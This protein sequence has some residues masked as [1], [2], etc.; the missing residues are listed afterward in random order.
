M[1]E[2]AWRG[3]ISC[4]TCPD[5]PFCKS[6]ADKREEDKTE[7]DDKHGYQEDCRYSILD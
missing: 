4:E 3:T 2:C 1:A 6:W 7:G 5:E